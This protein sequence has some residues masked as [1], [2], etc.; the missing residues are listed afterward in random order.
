MKT[1]LTNSRTIVRLTC[2]KKVFTLQ[3]FKSKT[4]YSSIQLELVKAFFN[5]THPNKKILVEEK[6]RRQYQQDDPMLENLGSPIGQIIWVVLQRSL[7]KASCKVCKK[8]KIT[9]IQ[10]MLIWNRKCYIRARHLKKQLS[11]QGMKSHNRR[12]K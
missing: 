7:E 5:K 9:R 10:I 6:T 4:L 1:K 3:L 11:H 8:F 12:Y 2:L